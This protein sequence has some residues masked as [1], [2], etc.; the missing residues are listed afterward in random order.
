MR[1]LTA[2]TLLFFASPAA[3]G[4]DPGMWL[5]CDTLGFAAESPTQDEPAVVMRSIT[6]EPIPSG[7]WSTVEVK[8]V[9]HDA[10][11]VHFVGLMTLTKDTEKYEIANATIRFRNSGGTDG[12][13]FPYQVQVVRIS[14]GGERSPFAGWVTVTDRRFDLLWERTTPPGYPENPGIGFRLYVDGYCR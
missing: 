1:L 8:T 7:E 13:L 3:A 10:V 9:P 14:F 5:E 12:R 6:D 2:L 11:A 4:Y